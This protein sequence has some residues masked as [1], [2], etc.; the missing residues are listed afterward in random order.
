MKILIFTASAGNG[1]NSA[2]HNLQKHFL[3]IDGNAQVKIV[4]AYKEYTSPIKNFI[5]TK[6][7]LALCD[8]CVWLYN[9]FFKK[10]EKGNFVHP[11]KL[12]VNRI[13]KSLQKGMLK[14]INE[15][16][17][18]LIFSTYIYCS[19]AL[20]NLKRKND[21]HVKTAS[22]ALDYGV[23]PFWECIAKNTDYM[24]IPNDSVKSQFIERGFNE[25][26]LFVTGIPVSDVYEKLPP[27]DTARKM[28]GLSAYKFTVL[29]MKSGF[30]TIKDKALIK[31]LK[32]TDEN[33]QAVVIN[34]TA[35]KSKKTIDKYILKHDLKHKIINYGFT[36]EIPTFFAACDA[37]VC[38]GGGLT[39]TEAVNAKIP[40]LIVDN[41]PV[42]EV[43]NK[44]FMV[45]N[46]CAVSTDKRTL[47]D[48]INGLLHDADKADSMRNNC[49]KTRTEKSC[50][51]IC[52]I[53]MGINA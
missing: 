44:I 49:A 5:Q 39:L 29:V 22:V 36:D 31:A 18:D 40:M 28:L 45:E 30:F 2:A 43:Y 10:A 53:L 35:E 7:Y 15:F 47:T 50:E 12:R 23:S 13:T 46:E 24:F 6:G 9:Y 27:K 34:G 20:S 4:D 19:I 37:V 26:V 8:R 38:K 1:H 32:N 14:E 41:L 16:A 52:N 11:E 17:P 51:R 21:I 42:Q 25:K 3:R 48:D 33:V